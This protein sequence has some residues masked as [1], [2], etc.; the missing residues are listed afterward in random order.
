MKLSAL[1]LKGQA[2]ANKPNDPEVQLPL[3]AFVEA[4]SAADPVETVEVETVEVEAVEVEAVIEAAE[5]APPRESTPAASLLDRGARTLRGGGA[6]H[7]SDEATSIGPE[8][9][10][11][12]SEIIEGSVLE[13]GA[14]PDIVCETET[15]SGDGS[16]TAIVD[17]LADAPADEAEPEGP[18]EVEDAVAEPETRLPRPPGAGNIAGEAP[19]AEPPAP[20]SELKAATQAAISATLAMRQAAAARRKPPMATGANARTI[21]APPVTEGRLPWRRAAVIAVGVALGLASYAMFSGPP[22]EA[23]IETAAPAVVAGPRAA[24]DLAVT[25]D[26]AGTKE[27]A[28][29][30]LSA[31]A[32]APAPPLQTAAA[33]DAGSPRALEPSFDI[34]RI[35]PDGQSIIAG[36]AEPFSEWILLNNGS[37]IASISADANG[38]WVVLPDASL[39]PGANAFSLVP[40]TERGKVAIPALEPT[41]GP[42]ETAPGAAF[43]PVDAGMASN[44]DTAALDDR[45]LALPRPKPQQTEV[46]SSPPPM[47]RV[48]A[49]GEYQ[50]QLASVRQSIDAERERVRLATAFPQL[51]GELDLRVQE[52]AVDGAGTFF[53]VRSGAIAQLGAAREVCRRLEGVG[54]GCLVVRRPL[55]APAGQT[56]AVEQDVETPVP[57]QQQAERPQ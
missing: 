35:E 53:R 29:E 22:Q 30:S 17:A 56:K 40:K 45:R 50:V 55:T 34:I 14:E 19:S 13:P 12:G 20:S 41:S 27:Q 42:P 8:A 54:Q 57:A 2:G 38:E 46:A 39:V 3:L 7:P 11:Q 32:G 10:A 4:P 48:S 25:A 26:I 21:A 43:A 1:K 44:A 47:F 33:T 23:P 49:E 18:V 24:A 6:H 36:R 28:A 52:A 9:P 16:I 15:I 5:E 37:P 51:L 31:P